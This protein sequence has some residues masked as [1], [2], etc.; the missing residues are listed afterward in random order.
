MDREVSYFT[1]HHQRYLSKAAINEVQLNNRAGKSSWK[2]ELD[3]PAGLSSWIIHTAVLSASC[4]NNVILIQALKRIR[5]VQ[6][7]EKGAAEQKYCKEHSC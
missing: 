5:C 2:I 7:C 1:V 3:S 6:I 4:N